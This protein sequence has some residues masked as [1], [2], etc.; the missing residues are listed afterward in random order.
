MCVQ[1]LLMLPGEK[2]A[3]LYKLAIDEGLNDKAEALGDFIGEVEEYY[4]REAYQARPNM[5]RKRPVR[6]VRSTRQQ[7]R[8]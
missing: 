7:Q 8:A 2:V 6:Q 4:V 3:A 5:V 1:K